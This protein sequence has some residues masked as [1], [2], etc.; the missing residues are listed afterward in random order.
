MPT[1]AVTG[2]LEDFVVRL[3]LHV[4]PALKDQTIILDRTQSW[5]P[6]CSLGQAQDI[7][8][9]LH[10]FRQR[11]IIMAAARDQNATEF[12]G[13][14]IG[15]FQDLSMLM[16]QRRRTLWPVTDFLRE[17]GIRYK[18]GQ[19]FRL[20]FVWQNETRSICTLEEAQGLKG[21]PP[22][23]GDQPQQSVTQEQPP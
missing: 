22:S 23:L 9:C 2:S 6:A 21:M 3:F 12:E 7:M 10:Y 5:P 16:L 4:A 8:T 18:W 20:H 1:P 19:P 13:Q 14:R 11:E 15:L 17:K